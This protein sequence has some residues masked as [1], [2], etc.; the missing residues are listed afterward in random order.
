[1]EYTTVNL[2]STAWLEVHLLRADEQS[3]ALLIYFLN[4]LSRCLNMLYLD[5]LD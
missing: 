2:T 1:M 3:F 5:T 4:L